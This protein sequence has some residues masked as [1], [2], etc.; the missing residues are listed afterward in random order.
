MPKNE[1]VRRIDNPVRRGGAGGGGTVLSP[2][3]GAASTLG[4]YTASEFARLAEACTVTG[5]W[6]FLT[7]IL[8]G[9]GITIDGMDPSAHA[10]D[11]A[12]HHDL[13]TAGDGIDLSGQQVSVDVTDLI[14][15]S[16]G[17]TENEN[18]I[19]VILSGSSLEFNGASG[20]RIAEAA[21]GAGLTGGGASALAVGAGTLIT[22]NAN[23]VALSVGSAQFQVPLTGANPYTPAWTTALADVSGPA[24]AILKSTAQGGVTLATLQVKGN[25]TV[26]DGGDFTVGSNVLFV[27]ESQGNVGVNCAPDPQFD[28]DIAGHAR[29]QG[30][31]VA[32]AAI[33]LSDVTFLA[34]FDGY[35]PHFWDFTGEFHDIMGRVGTPTKAAIF[36]P[37][38]FGTKALQLAPA[39]T[40]LCDN[41]S[42]ETNLTNWYVYHGG[43][44]A[45]TRTRTSEGGV[46]G[47]P[48]NK[49]LYCMK[50]V[51]TNAGSSINDIQY[52]WS[53][54]SAM[55]GVAYTG[56]VWLRASTARQ[57]TL[58]LQK[59]GSPYTVY[60]T[61]VH[62]VTTE[63]QRFYL[64][65]TAS[66]TEA[67]RF[68]VALGNQGTNTV[69][70]DAVQIEQ[71]GYPTPYCDGGLGGRD[72]AGNYDGT[73]HQWT[74]TAHGSTSTRDGHSYV[75][76]SSSGVWNPSQ[77]T[78]MFWMKVP[79]TTPTAA[80]PNL[81]R[82]FEYGVYSS[83]AAHQWISAMFDADWNVISFS[84]KNKDGGSYSVGLTDNEWADG[85]WHHFA[86]VW[87]DGAT[88]KAYVD[89]SATA[90]E[91][92]VASTYPLEYSSWAI[93]HTSYQMMGYIEDFVVRDI[94]TSAAEVRSIY[95][96]DAMVFAETSVWSFKI[97]TNRNYIWADH[98]GLW[99]RDSGGNSILGLSVIDSKGWGGHT[100]NAG[101]F[102]LGYG[103]NV[104]LWDIS[105][106]S[107]RIGNVGANKSNVYVKAGAVSLRNN[108]TERIGLTAAGILTVKD[109][110]GNAVITLDADQGA[111]ITK[112]L[113][114]PGE[115]SAISIGAPPPTAVDS[116]TGIWIDRTGMYG[117]LANVLQ[118]KFDAVTGAV[119]AGAEKTIL[120]AEGI[121]LVP[122]TT[123][124]TSSAVDW[125]SNDRLRANV[126]VT[127]NAGRNRLALVA[128]RNLESADE[129]WPQ[130]NL[131]QDDYDVST[132]S[133]ITFYVLE[134]G[135]NGYYFE[136]GPVFVE[137]GLNVDTTGA[138]PGE[139]K[140]SGDA[141]IGGD[142]VI[143]GILNA[144]GQLYTLAREGPVARKKI[145]IT[146]SGSKART[147]PSPPFLISMAF[148]G[149]GTG[150]ANQAFGV[151]IFSAVK[152]YYD[153]WL[154]NWTQLVNV[155]G[156]GT[157]TMTVITNTST[158]LSVELTQVS[159][160][161]DTSGCY[162]C[163][164][165]L[166]FSPYRDALTVA[167]VA[168]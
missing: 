161:I 168:V 113:T 10:A 8:L 100:L 152:A 70:I 81:V 42:F 79:C 63:W 68:T 71:K 106:T 146:W 31:L 117:L 37:G 27:D 65:A 74:G 150:D 76:Y 116:G 24:E 82:I 75:T 25:V 148:R 90:G 14:E 160:G 80:L 4:G 155:G 112:K 3:A 136:N 111:E 54:F 127:R 15:A 43:T 44:A 13:V 135:D 102:L 18:N 138:G 77:G 39:T 32:K 22:V 164:S 124:V 45:S 114:M 166:R 19:R 105:D 67:A 61:T 130:I 26:T 167:I 120:D 144:H 93:G 128:R 83:P 49:T 62:S 60:G 95:E 121:T 162:G 141:L 110:A 53:T 109:S 5:A 85:D 66:G 134:A 17:L 7:A 149:T 123:F 40:N 6:T 157:I 78:V 154:V 96:S 115:N 38:K 52:Y 119:T 55:D 137:K 158:A 139:L 28:L 59:H 103:D 21:A 36:R 153:D 97:N 64:I 108:V 9:S 73:G 84:Y 133:R 50:A 101:D 107:I 91:S 142:A 20:I 88:L 99:A 159:G 57:V 140:T 56:S 104:M 29:V 118:A 69:W 41:P 89:G 16:Y 48:A 72:T 58:T 46:Y 145:T 163:Y 165:V 11:S 33:Q 98:E 23:D 126:F 129:L 132:H 131:T 156:K 151:G 35:P 30:F 122:G 87:E 125:K 2:G 86:F 94:A 147:G 12:A 34:H 1:P 51:I 47:D 92:I 143:T